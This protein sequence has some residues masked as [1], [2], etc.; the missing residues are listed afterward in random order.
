MV[1]VG[2]AGDEDEA[3]RGKNGGCILMSVGGGKIACQ[4]DANV[5]VE[6]RAPHEDEVLAKFVDS[7]LFSIALFATLRGVKQKFKGFTEALSGIKILEL[8]RK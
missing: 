2:R 4:G 1:K 8:I 3:M 6:T 5:R 7:V